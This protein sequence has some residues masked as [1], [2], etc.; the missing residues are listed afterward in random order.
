MNNFSKFLYRGEGL[1]LVIYSRGKSGDIIWAIFLLVLDFFIMFPSIKIGTKGLFLWLVLTI[2]LFIFLLKTILQ[3]ETTYLL[4][5]NRLVSLPKGSILLDH[6]EDVK[7]SGRHDICLIVK[8]CKY[9]LFN[10][11]DRDRV[12]QK[13]QNLV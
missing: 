1:R 2:C 5:T 6:I 8:G 11:K 3:K 10:I 9:F 12:Y 4:T 7:K 13:M